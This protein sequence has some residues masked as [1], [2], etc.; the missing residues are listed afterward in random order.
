MY[1]FC[2]WFI[3]LN[4]ILG[5]INFVNIIYM[6]YKIIANGWNCKEYVS[7]CIK[8]VLAQTYKNWELILISDGSTDGTGEAIRWDHPQIVFHDYKDQ[9]GSAYRRY[10]AITA[11]DDN[12]SVIV[13]LDLDD[14]LLPNAL[15][16][17]EEEYKKGK[18][19]TYGNYITDKGIIYQP[20]LLHFSDDTH[21]ERSYRKERWRSTHLKT[22]KRYLFDNIDEVDF[23]YKDKWMDCT[24]ESPLMFALL[25]M[26]G[27]DR[28]GVVEEPIYRYR[29]VTPNTESVL[30]THKYIHEVYD[31]VCSLPKYHLI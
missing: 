19:M 6:K 2:D 25:E 17:V 22:F 29:S 12:D 27:K 13:M 7:D 4:I 15:E 26:C 1:R 3:F 28:I 30:K 11:V 20:H 14:E 16:R 10:E 5:V 8:S 21:H 23:F 24:P 9:K 31:H 18:L